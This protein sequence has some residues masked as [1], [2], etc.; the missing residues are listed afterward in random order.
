M[1]PGKLVEIMELA[2]N[3]KNAT[4]HS[5][6][7]EGRHES[8]AEHCWRLCLFAYFIRDEFPDADMEKVMRMCLIHDM[9]EAFTGDIPAFEKTPEHEAVE[10]QALQ[11]WVDSLPEPYSEE[12]AG[13]YDELRRQETTEARIVKAL[14]S[15]EAVMQHNQ[16]DISTWLPLEYELQL[17]YGVDKTVFS[18][19]LSCLR[20]FV[21]DESR[22][23]IDEHNSE[24]EK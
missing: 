10:A 19:Y 2:E 6:T 7:S 23:K 9:G 20:E 5:W 4:R 17:T 16:A 1:E 21:A 11:R 15:M 13:L 12:L 3:L 8:V 22:R 18:D 24:K 14:D